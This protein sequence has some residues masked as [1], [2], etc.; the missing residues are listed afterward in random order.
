MY[1]SP[2]SLP[3]RSVES[4]IACRVSGIINA[5]ATYYE[6]DFEPGDTILL[7]RSGI[8]HG[9]HVYRVSGSSMDDGSDTAIRHGDHVLVATRD[10]T[11][12]YGAVFAYSCPTGA[13]MVKRPGLYRGQRA[14]L[15]DNTE[16]PPIMRAHLEGIVPLGR[17]YAVYVAPG[18]I[19]WVR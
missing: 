1:A 12:V 16:H 9:T 5:S 19:R 6:P 17:V 11:T 4:V 7:P 15:S 10:H 3:S 14:L 8:R 2:S 13:I 18:Q